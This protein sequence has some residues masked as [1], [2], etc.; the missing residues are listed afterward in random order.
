MVFS[1][2]AGQRSQS[3]VRT[4]VARFGTRTLD[5]LLKVLGRNHAE[6][7]GYAGLQAHL[8]NT[9]GNLVAHIIIVRSRTAYDSAQTDDR[10]VLP[11]LRELLRRERYLKCAR[12]PGERD[13]TH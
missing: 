4:L 12:H 7:H 2:S 8:R 3:R 10:A 6:Q 11:A 1:L 13:I 5:G 9:L